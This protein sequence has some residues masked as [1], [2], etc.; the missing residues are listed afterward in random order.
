MRILVVGA[1]ATGGY[2]GGRLAQAGRGVTF[3][4]RPARAEQ[5]RA[6]G[7]QIVSP[8]GDV[9]LTPQT[10][11]TG[12]SLPTFDV[13]VLAVKA[14]GLASAIEDFAGA[15][16]PETMIVPLLNGMRHIDLL[17]ERFGERPVLGGL[18]FIATTLDGDGRI[19]HLARLHDLTYGERSGETSQRVRA[20]DAV[21]QGAGFDAH[22][23]TRVLPEMWEKWITLASLGG[24][25]CLMR[26]TIGDVAAAPGGVEFAST[27]VDE[28]V[29]TAT[30]A[31]FAQDPDFVARTRAGM[32]RAGST[33][34]SSMYRDLQRGN[35]VE[36]DQILG[37]L[38]AR[39]RN[40]GIA[41]PLLAAAYANLKVYQAAR[42]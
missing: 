15:V 37:D 23:S 20:L 40:F 21:M 16:G 9:T 27:L 7:L 1:G 11:T 36:A 3:L 14:F 28:C 22:L 30:A 32:T 34:T 8:R 24:I 38:I 41:T 26:G 18:C 29:A 13:V 4:V 5:L 42:R 25:T 39:A 2:V 17:I 10:V 19:I 35:D 33:V 31:G 6:Q 12:S